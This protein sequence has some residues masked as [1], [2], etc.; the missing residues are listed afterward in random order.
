MQIN[1]SPE[2]EA[3]ILECVK[4]GGYTSV[5]DVIT[6]AVLHLR[7]SAVEL[8]EDVIRELE[9]ADAEIEAGKGIDFE[10]FKAEMDKKYESK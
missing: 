4:T 6:A 7:D 1:L 2:V 9:E 5:E 3:Y 8:P 10:T